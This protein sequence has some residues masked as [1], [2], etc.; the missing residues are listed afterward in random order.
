MQRGWSELHI[1]SWFLLGSLVFYTAYSVFSIPYQTLAMEMSPDYHEKTR[2]VAWRE[3]VGKTS[4]VLLGWLFFFTESFRDPVE[5][6]RWLSLGLGILFIFCGILPGLFIKERFYKTVSRQ[7]KIPIAESLKSTFSSGSFRLVSGIVLLTLLGNWAS[8]YF[9]RYVNIY[10]IFEGDT[11]SASVIEGWR[12]TAEMITAVASIPLFTWLSRKCGK[13]NALK[14]IAGCIMFAAVSRLVLVN[15]EHPWW[16]VA[17]AALTGPGGGGVWLILMSMLAD[18]CDEDELKTGC[19]REGSYASIFQLMIKIGFSIAFLL[20][21]LMLEGAGFD[22]SLE[23]AQS[24][25]SLWLMRGVFTLLPVA[26]M[27][28]VFGL[29]HRYSLDEARCHEIRQEL[30]ERRG[31]L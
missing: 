17:N 2:I 13:V 19:R 31:S 21:N 3:M 1:F 6:M 25:Q 10:Y 4:F 12:R 20:A 5:G 11:H 18:I 24:E 27:L 29:I 15:A 9:G 30:E 14:V 16:M 22:A 28:G 26:A 7:R 8:N 23:G